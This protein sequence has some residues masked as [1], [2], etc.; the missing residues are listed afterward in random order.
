M[1]MIVTIILFT[2]GVNFRGFFEFISTMSLYTSMI[3]ARVIH[4]STS[5]T[6]S[7]QSEAYAISMRTMPRPMAKYS[8][9]CRCLFF[10]I[11]ALCSPAM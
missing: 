5:S 8:I 9:H 3:T 11:H 2:L 7:S 1:T 6:I 4:I 10:L